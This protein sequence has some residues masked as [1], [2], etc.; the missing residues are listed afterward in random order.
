[1]VRASSGGIV[2]ERLGECGFTLPPS[3]YESFFFDF[4][5]LGFG[6]GTAADFGLVVGR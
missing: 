5:E 4:G 3:G 1:M 2:E 6:F